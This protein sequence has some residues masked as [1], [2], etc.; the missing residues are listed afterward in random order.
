MRIL[1]AALVTSVLAVAPAAAQPYRWVDE[2]G[3]VNYTDDINAV[4]PRFRPKETPQSP[5]RRDPFAPA[6]PRGPGRAPVIVPPDAAPVP[7]SPGDK[8]ETR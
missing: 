1:L 2:H 6:E 5:T 7:R 8:K 3:T 4:P